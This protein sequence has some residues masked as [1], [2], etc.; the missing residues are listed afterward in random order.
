MDGS[1]TTVCQIVSRQIG[2]RNID[3]T[4]PLWSALFPHSMINIRG[5]I[6]TENSSSFLVQM[7][8]NPSRELVAVAFSPSLESETQPFD[9]IFNHLISKKW[10]YFSAQRGV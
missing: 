9:K 5:R 8:L 10:V 6:P 2:G 7:R 3:S 1:T 4:S